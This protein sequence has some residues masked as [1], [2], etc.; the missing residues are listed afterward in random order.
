M[1]L[2]RTYPTDLVLAVVDLWLFGYPHRLQM[3]HLR[4]GLLTFEKR[5]LLLQ[6]Q[7]C[8][9]RTQLNPGSVALPSVYQV[10]CV[11][12]QRPT[13]DG[14]NYRGGGWCNRAP[15]LPRVGLWERN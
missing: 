3:A 2:R 1:F 15:I 11:A 13:C 10:K 8:I 5:R 4:S 6:M 7:P 9:R 12:L 14:A